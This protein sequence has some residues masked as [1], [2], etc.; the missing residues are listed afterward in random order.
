MSLSY[1]SLESLAELQDW[2]DKRYSAV[3]QARGAEKTFLYFIEEV[4]ELATAISRGDREN[5][6]EEIGDVL[7][8]LVSLANLTGA[9]LQACV[10]AYLRRNA[11]TK[12]KN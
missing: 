1:P 7:M 4:G 12:P 6:H 8:W 11:G 3:D 5:I 9:D 2:A 10:A